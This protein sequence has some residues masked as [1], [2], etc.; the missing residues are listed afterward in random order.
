MIAG[1]IYNSKTG[2]CEKIARDVAQALGVSAA[3]MGAA[4]PAGKVIYV[5]WTLAAGV[6]GL[7]KAME[8]YDIAAV[9]QVGMGAV[10][11]ESAAFA[12]KSNNI[13]DSIAVFSKQGGFHIK[14]LPLHFRLIMSLKDKEIVSRLMSKGELNM[15]ERATLHMASTGDGEPASWDVSDIVAWAKQN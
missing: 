15:Q 2:S 13:P 5:G 14:K 10:T 12:R 8:K 3:P 4:A 11:D 1:I 9:V 7:K 6:V